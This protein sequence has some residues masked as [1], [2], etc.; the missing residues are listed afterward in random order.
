MLGCLFFQV[1]GSLTS[2][3]SQTRNP[4]LKVP[5]GGLLL[6]IFMSWKSLSTSVGFE[7]ANLRSRG[8][9]VTPRPP[10][11]TITWPNYEI[12]LLLTNLSL[13]GFLI[14]SSNILTE[15]NRTRLYCILYIH[16]SSEFLN[17]NVLHK[18]NSSVRFHFAYNSVTIC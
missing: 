3:K 2:L 1:W 12:V 5:S 6:R 9:H 7:P 8:E 11:P 14:Y 4:K 13:F 15:H 10:R 16:S 17:H 18:G